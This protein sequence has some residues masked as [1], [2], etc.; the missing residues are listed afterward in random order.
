MCLL[1]PTNVVGSSFS[2]QSVQIVRK[3]VHNV[4]A[5]LQRDVL[6]LLYGICLAMGVPMGKV[7]RPKVMIIGSDEGFCYLMKR[8]VTECGCGVLLHGCTCRARIAAGEEQPAA[9]LLE[10]G[11]PGTS[12]WTIRE[13]LQR[14][15]STQEIP[16][17]LCYWLEE[18]TSTLPTGGAHLLRKP[19]LYGDVY[20]VLTQVGVLPVRDRSTG[21]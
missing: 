6:Y 1:A 5:C 15:A 16:L 14:D 7:T 11:R 19:I 8:Y 13:S 2:V 17:V 18:E 12:R 4:L 21:G 9:I 3:L 20:S 10:I